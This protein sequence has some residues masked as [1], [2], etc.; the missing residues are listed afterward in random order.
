MN[1][2]KPGDRLHTPAEL[3]AA[4]EAGCTVRDADGDVAE[5]GFGG[6][7]AYQYESHVVGWLHHRLYPFE[8]VSVKGGGS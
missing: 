2:Y 6:V 7:L 4:L 1:N 8:V 5:R 3:T